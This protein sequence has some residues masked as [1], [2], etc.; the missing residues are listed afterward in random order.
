M[1]QAGRCLGATAST[2]KAHG[3]KPRINEAGKI[4]AKNV[5]RIDERPTNQKAQK[6]CMEK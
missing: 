5:S 6:Q 2:S 3:T 4:W 1:A